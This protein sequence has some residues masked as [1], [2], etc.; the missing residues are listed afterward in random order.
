M[1]TVTRLCKATLLLT[2][3]LLASGAGAQTEVSFV[4]S[5][6]A[7]ASAA[8]TYRT[9]WEQYGERIVKAFETRTCLP[10]P[11]PKVSAVITDAVSNSGGP[12]HAMQLRA[13]YPSVMKQA[14][15]VH[16]LGHRHLWQLARRFPEIDGHRTL[17]LVLDLVWADVWGEGFA[18]EAIRQ[19]SA[20][21]A[22]YDYAAAWKSAR[23]LN[24]DERS[25][26]WNGLLVL[27]GF[28]AGCTGLAALNDPLTTPL[29]TSK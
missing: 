24:L 10:F 13:T 15:L 18:A 7:Y 5:S 29:P 28:P 1:E 2:G 14:T 11:E 26:L 25:R 20:W 22:D 6:A 19:E 4:A 9:I 12:E 27:N 23:S 8:K 16:E 17:Y 3:S 21:D